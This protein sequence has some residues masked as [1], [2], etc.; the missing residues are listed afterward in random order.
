MGLRSKFLLTL[1]IFSVV[2]LLGFFL[3]NQKLFDRLG[4]EVYHIAK[5]LL[6]Q[7]AAKELEESADNYSR[8][9]NRE[10]S[11]ILGHV[12]SVRDAIEGALVHSQVAASQKDTLWIQERVAEQLAIKFPGIKEYGDHLVSVQFFAEQGF[13]L[14]Y[15]VGKETETITNPFQKIPQPEAD[16]PLWDLPAAAPGAPSTSNEQHIIVG[17]PVSRPDN[18]ILG[19]IAIDFD[20][21][22]LFENIRPASQWSPYVQSFL[23]RMNLSMNAKSGLPLVIGIRNP[24]SDKAEWKAS[25]FHLK[26]NPDFEGEATALFEG[27]QYGKEGYVSVPYAGKVSIWAFATA[28]IG[29]GILNILPEREV[30]FRIARH[31]ERFSRWLSLDSLLIVSALVLV[32]VII[33][34]FRSRR[35]LAPFFSMVSAFENVSKGD[36]STK[37]D[38]NV[39]DERQMIADAFNNMTIQLEDGMRMR[40][41]LEVAK[42]VQHNFFPEIDSDNSDLDIAVRMSYCEETG[43]DY[44]DVLHEKDGKVCIVVGDVTGHG[45]GAALLM[46]TVRSLIRGR[47]EVD[48]DLSG[49]ITS[50]N[51]KLSADMGDSGRFVTLFIVEINP[52][53]RQLRWVRAGHDPAWLFRNTDCSIV[54]LSGP[55]VAM[56]VDC[57]LTYSENHRDQLESGDVILIG[58]DGIWETSGSDGTQFGKHRLERIVLENAGRTASEICDSLIDR[59]DQFRGDQKPEDDVSVVVIKIP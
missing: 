38:F 24:L 47:Y 59:V 11:L 21:I 14:R 36:F 25:T 49:V 32:M 30:L 42:E 45:V 12:E 26:I 13:Y 39:R 2:P 33:V 10:L 5:V 19:Y 54:P 50:A 17:L 4:D 57:D 3:I 37:L 35:M 9:L 31:P 8:N 41:G 29:L 56:G 18:S 7:T 28:E 48:T 34:A 27:M 1:I 22:K 44:I 46:A 16:K 23:L 15:P 52:A 55:G 53:S 58:T 51:S 20:F 40:Q 43:G 6:L